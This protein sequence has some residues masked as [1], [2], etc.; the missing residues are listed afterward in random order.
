VKAWKLVSPIYFTSEEAAE[1]NELLLVWEVRV[2]MEKMV[3]SLGNWRM[4]KLGAS[5]V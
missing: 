5:A 4:E 3:E 2:E 1:V